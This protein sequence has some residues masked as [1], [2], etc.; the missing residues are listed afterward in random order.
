[1]EYS[2]LKRM[3]TLPINESIKFK[4]IYLVS[5]NCKLQIN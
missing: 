2:I 5:A 4:I 3:N 1:M